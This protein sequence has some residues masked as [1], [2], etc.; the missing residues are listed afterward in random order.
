MRKNIGSTGSS[1]AGGQDHASLLPGM[2]EEQGCK[3]L[4]RGRAIP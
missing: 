4:D 3:L 2:A 1:L